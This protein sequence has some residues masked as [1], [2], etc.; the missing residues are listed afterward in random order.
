M[1]TGA[2]RYEIHMYRKLEM[3]LRELECLKE[4]VIMIADKLKVLSLP[5]LKC[6]H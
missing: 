2:K 1:E 4:D 6:M 3:L 5:K